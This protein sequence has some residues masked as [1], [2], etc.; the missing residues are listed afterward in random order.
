MRTWTDHTLMIFTSLGNATRCPW[1]S[2]KN[3]AAPGQGPAAQRVL[4]GLEEGE[5]CVHMMTVAPGEL[6]TMPDLLFY[7]ESGQVK[8]SPAVEYDVKRSKFAAIGLKDDALVSVTVLQP[9]A[10]QFC[11]THSGMMIR[12]SQEDIPESGR[13]TRGVRAIRLAQGDRLRWA[14]NLMNSDQLI[15]FSERGYA[16]RLMGSMADRQN[17]GGKGVH[18]FYFNKS[19]NN[20]SYIAA[21]ATL[22]A[23]RSFSVLQANG[24]MSSFMSEEIAP[25]SLTERG[26]PY[27]MA[28]L[29]NVVTDLVL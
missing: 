2:W 15:L 1:A 16:K 5:A 21:F 24:E 18:A 3:P 23:P 28:L 26:K 6:E 8:R 9:D 17:R 11:L 12:F 14:G 29:D 19:G 22:A 10:D 13:T 20:G 4:S 25:Q 7:T 27:V